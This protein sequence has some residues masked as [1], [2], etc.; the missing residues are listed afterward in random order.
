MKRHNAGTFLLLG[1][2]A[3]TCICVGYEPDWVRVYS[4]NANEEFAFWS[5]HMMRNPTSIGGIDVDDDGAIT[6]NTVGIGISIHTGGHIVT[7]AEVAAFM[8]LKR[9]ALD[10]SKEANVSAGYYTINKWNFVTGLTG[11]WNNPCDT[12]YVGPGSFIWIEGKRHLITA[13]TSNGEVSAEVTL[14]V[15]VATG[16]IQRITNMYDYKTMTTGETT[17]AGF[18]ID[19]DADVLNA[20]SE[21][22]WFE[23]GT[24]DC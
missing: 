17:K 18:M 9:D 5:V 1:T 4:H 16:D 2:S 24:Y 15:A 14:D 21:I 11:Y 23:C 3:D 6:P 13:L 10:Y 8:Y 20:T 22:A 12:S 7:A 19:A